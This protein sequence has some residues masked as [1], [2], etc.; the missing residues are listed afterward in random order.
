MATGQSSVCSGFPAVRAPFWGQLVTLRII[1]SNF[2]DS[3]IYSG[4][5]D[6]D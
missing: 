4:C 6:A 5:L 2:M 3:V 1:F